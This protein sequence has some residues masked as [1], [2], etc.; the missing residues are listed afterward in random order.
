VPYRVGACLP[1]HE[2]RFTGGVLGFWAGR[3][4]L[5]WPMNERERGVWAK[6]PPGP[7]A[8]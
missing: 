1:G 8:L 5:W 6:R 4:L 2:S 3:T 7:R